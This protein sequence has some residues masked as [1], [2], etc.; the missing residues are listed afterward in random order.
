[1][2]QSAAAIY[3]PSGV[4]ESYTK[5]IKFIEVFHVSKTTNVSLSSVQLPA[6]NPTPSVGELTPFSGTRVSMLSSAMRQDG[7]HRHHHN[8]SSSPLVEKTGALSLSQPD[9]I[10]NNSVF[11]EI[12]LPG[13]T[14]TKPN[15]T[16]TVLAVN[17][18][19][20]GYNEPMSPMTP[21]D[22]PPV[23]PKMTTSKEVAVSQKSP[24]KNFSYTNILSPAVAKVQEQEVQVNTSRLSIESM[25]TNPEDRLFSLDSKSVAKGKN[26]FLFIYFTYIYI[27]ILFQ[28]SNLLYYEFY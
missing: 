8:S 24:I 5:I 19:M 28:S 9:N 26:Y 20:D 2:K 15:Q 12:P 22:R 1:M 3:D 21:N 4:H 6:E 18:L 25:M 23:F 7:D 10:D 13:A 17:A 14:K 27:Y 11:D 16:S